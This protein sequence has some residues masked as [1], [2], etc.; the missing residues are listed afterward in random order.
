MNVLKEVEECDEDA[1]EGYNQQLMK[2]SLDV[3]TAVCDE[4]FEEPTM[5]IEALE[6]MPR[7]S[8]S[9]RRKVYT[10][11]PFLQMFQIFESLH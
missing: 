5:C 11:T 10:K 8:P 1:I 2:S 4:Y 9:Q 6:Y 7:F 3:L